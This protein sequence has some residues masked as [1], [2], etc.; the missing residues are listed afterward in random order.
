MNLKNIVKRY[1]I[2]A[3]E[4]LNLAVESFDLS[5]SKNP[6][7]GDL[8]TNVAL[9]L[10]KIVRKNPMEIAK[11]IK[12]VI[13]I[14]NSI[15]SEI[16]V[17][18]PGFINFKISPSYYQSVLQQI[19]N[20]D[21]H[22]YSGDR[23][24]G[25]TANVEFVSANPTGPL[26]VGHGRQAVIGDTVASIL[27][28]H[29]YDVTREYY[30]ND[31]GKQMRI[32]AKSVETR[33]FQEIGKNAEWSDDFYQGDYIKDIAKDIIK[34]FGENVNV[35]DK[36]FR[37]AAEERI[38]SN[39]RNTLEHIGIIHDVFSNE[40]NYI[41]PEK[42]KELTKD[43]SN[44]NLI[45]ENEGAT[46]FKTT[47]LGK[48]Q[49]RVLI[50]SSGEPAYRLPDILYHQDKFERKYDFLIDI[51]GADHIDSYP[52]VVSA[53]EALGYDTSSLRVLIHQFVTLT[54]GGEK[55]KMSTR[56]AEF[57]TL[58]EL[59]NLVGKDVVRYFFLMRGM[60]THLNFDIE[61]AQDQSDNNPVYYLQYAHARICNII[62]HG[63]QQ[64]VTFNKDY[65]PSLL[66]EH[67]E[68]ELMKQLNQFP[69]RMATVLESLEPRSITNYL[70]TLARLF[71][72]FYTE[73]H[74]ITDNVSLSQARIALISATK[75]ILA[76]GLNIL[77]ISAPERM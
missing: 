48:D 72:K 64:G 50:K 4:K 21:E 40:K 8:S 17:K 28:W 2:D 61:L 55:V 66:I 20:T 33:Y 11:E 77:G 47:S 57:V 71:H 37:K 68:I 36:I 42:I 41:K 3:L 31:G 22:F 75:I 7:F 29:G 53:L 67:A 1:L 46:W 16:N 30:Y 13:P 52:D 45:Y 51:F 6:K 70:Q 39:I 54:K 14:D 9:I 27:Q 49:D 15:L 35:G 12:Q 18:P 32:L 62:R 69:E 63:E 34:E 58:D 10:A 23:G 74:V 19:I 43:L 76:E 24:K 60:N 26:S 56:K 44:K 73:C 59:I 25:K 5:D 65:N 38:F